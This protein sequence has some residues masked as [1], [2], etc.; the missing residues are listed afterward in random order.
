MFSPYFILPAGWAV[1][2]EYTVRFIAHRENHLPKSPPAMLSPRGHAQ[3]MMSRHLAF[4][5]LEEAEWKIVIPEKIR[6]V[7]G[8]ATAI[9]R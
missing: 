6:T 3:E 1:S 5:A 9:S 7:K 2:S 4:Q 8:T